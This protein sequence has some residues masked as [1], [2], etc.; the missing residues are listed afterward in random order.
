MNC[1]VLLS[2]LMCSTL[3]LHLGGCG[4]KGRLKFPKETEHF[5]PHI[6]PSGPYLP[7]QKNLPLE[8]IVPSDMSE[9]ERNSVED[10]IH[11]NDGLSQFPH[12]P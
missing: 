2:L 8:G 5:Y 11:E 10:A 9:K 4:K 3:C 1:K 12:T 6:Y 7:N